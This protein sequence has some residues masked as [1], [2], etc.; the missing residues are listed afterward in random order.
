MEPL[1]FIEALGEELAAYTWERTV[2][3]GW[4]SASYRTH[5]MMG[6]AIRTRK[7]AP[8]RGENCVIKRLL[9]RLGFTP[10]NQGPSGEKAVYFPEGRRVDVVACRCEDK[11]YDDCWRGEYETVMAAEVENDIREFTLT[12][13]GL[14]DVRA[15]SYFGIFYTWEMD[16]DSMRVGFGPQREPLKPLRDWKPP[17]DSSRVCPVSPDDAP[18]V[19]VFL[20]DREPR[21]VGARIYRTNAAPRDYPRDFVRRP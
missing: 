8:N 16:L 17:W 14:L 15:Q 6:T 5:H 13:R 20:S 3:L 21:L 4:E 12:M 11:W 7:E 18:L 2:G 9:Q 10:E 1:T 19:A